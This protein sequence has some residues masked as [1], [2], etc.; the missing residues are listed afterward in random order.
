MLLRHISNTWLISQTAAWQ[1]VTFI[2]NVYDSYTGAT[3]VTVYSI[4][5]WIIP[6]RDRKTETDSLEF[7]GERVDTMCGYQ[8]LKGERVDTMCGYQ[9]LPRSL[10]PPPLKAPL[11]DLVS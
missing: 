7:K 3:T 2:H 5:R 1:M 6:V 9:D 10:A 8:D 4:E 11:R